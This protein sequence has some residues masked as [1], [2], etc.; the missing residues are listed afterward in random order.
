MKIMESWAVPAADNY[1]IAKMHGGDVL[2]RKHLDRAMS[3][4]EKRRLAVDG[5]AHVGTWTRKMSKWFERVISFEPS[6][7]SFECLVYNV[8][9]RDNIDLRNQAL[10]NGPGRVRMT[11]EGFDKAIESGNT[12]A[13]FVAEGDE[14]ERISLD[15]LE[16]DCVDFLKL[17]VEGSEMN[18]ML[19]AEETLKRCK[20]VVLFEDKDHGR[21]YGYGREAPSELLMSLGAVWLDTAGCDQIWGWK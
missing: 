5:G 2:Q 13:M 21:R 17:D 15:S 9:D 4:V 10:G 11:L 6:A 7:E 1:T 20:P 8:K 12:M 14:V 18:A 3:F 19:G 16:L